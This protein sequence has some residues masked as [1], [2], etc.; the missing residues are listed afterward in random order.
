[1]RITSIGAKWVPD[2]GLDT[3]SASTSAALMKAVGAHTVPLVLVDLE[4]D[5]PVWTE[6]LESLK[7]AKT[8]GTHLNK[9]EAGNCLGHIARLV[10]L[11]ARCE[12]KRVDLLR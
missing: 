9:F 5:E 10:A 7:A 12:R 4:M 6:A 3:V 8:P 11:G 2:R 1:M